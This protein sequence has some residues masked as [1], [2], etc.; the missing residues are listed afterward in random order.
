[1]RVEARDFFG[2]IDITDDYFS[3]SCCVFRS[4]CAIFRRYCIGAAGGFLFW[5][6]LTISNLHRSRKITKDYRLN[7]GLTEL[8]Q[9]A[10]TAGVK[11]YAIAVGTE[12]FAA[13]NVKIAAKCFHYLHK[14]ICL[15]DLIRIIIRTFSV[16]AII[17]YAFK[18][19]IIS[20]FISSITSLSISLT[21]YPKHSLI[22]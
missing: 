20:F 7:F 1:M 11:I 5:V 22:W 14:Q 2:S 10:L 12:M 4:Y 8:I 17:I 19:D 16:F 18:N 21:Q 3:F 13:L 9:T 15:F 6:G